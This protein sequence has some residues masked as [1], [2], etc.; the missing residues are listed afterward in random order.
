M[1]KT[2]QCNLESLERLKI[3]SDEISAREAKEAEDKKDLVVRLEKVCGMLENVKMTKKR[4]LEEIKLI[5]NN[6]S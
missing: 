3:L 5:I 4:V 6:Y 1:A 2:L